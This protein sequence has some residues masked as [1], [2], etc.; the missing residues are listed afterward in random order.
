MTQTISIG[1]NTIQEILIRLR[2]L[3]RDVEEIKAHTVEDIPMVDEETEKRIGQ[4]LK[5]LAEGRYTVLKTKKD[6]EN[7]VENL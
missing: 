1:T 3:S 6:I 4:S 2:K 5:D 7:F